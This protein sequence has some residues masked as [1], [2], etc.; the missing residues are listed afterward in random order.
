MPP[1]IKESECVGCGACIDICPEGVIEL[2]EGISKVK[3]PNKCI[4][5]WACLTAC[6]LGLISKGDGKGKRFGM[7]EDDEEVL[8]PKPAK[9][10]KKK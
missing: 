2:D 5:C 1:K 10:K 4:N 3:N 7:D 9:T 8:E 6:P